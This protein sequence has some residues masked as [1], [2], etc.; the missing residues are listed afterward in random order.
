MSANRLS[1]INNGRV[2]GMGSKLYDQFAQAPREQ[3]IL[4]VVVTVLVLVLVVY[5][6]VKLAKSYKNFHSSNVLLVPGTIRM[7]DVL[8]IDGSKIPRSVDQQY[9]I[10]FSYANWMFIQRLNNLSDHSKGT[11]RHVYHKGAARINPLGDI[12]TGD[13]GAVQAPGV[14]LDSATNTMHIVVN[15][16]PNGKS[17]SVFEVC[18]I[19]N[20]PMQTWFHLAIVCINKNIDVFIN[21]RLKIRHALN[22]IPRLNYGDLYVGGDSYNGYLSNLYY[23]AHALQ[24]FELDKL[25]SDGPAAVLF[26]TPKYNEANL[27]QDW[28]LTTSYPTGGYN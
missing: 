24:I 5:L 3:Q 20:V 22:G 26:K 13:I 12:K 8:K 6:V 11:L 28:Y 25:V 27:S 7:D 16:F 21:G 2:G 4:S 9:G 17:S 23:F 10:E 18:S 19:E 1:N 15:T 14:W